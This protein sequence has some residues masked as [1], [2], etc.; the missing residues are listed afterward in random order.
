MQEHPA[1]QQ[2]ADVRLIMDMG[3]LLLAANA[4]AGAGAAGKAAKAESSSSS[5]G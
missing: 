3:D 4:L 1:L 5:R 2:S